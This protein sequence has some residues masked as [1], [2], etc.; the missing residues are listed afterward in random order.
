MPYE[1]F[2]IFT[3]LLMRYHI[4]TDYYQEQIH[5]DLIGEGK[6]CLFSPDK[7]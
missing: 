2:V 7:T 1:N 3:L 4:K 6:L 5:F